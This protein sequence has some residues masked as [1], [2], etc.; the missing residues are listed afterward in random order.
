MIFVAI[1]LFFVGYNLTRLPEIFKSRKDLERRIFLTKKEPLITSAQIFSK[2]KINQSAAGIFNNANDKKKENFKKDIILKEFENYRLLGIIK[3][4][5]AVAFIE[6]IDK[7]RCD[8]FR[9]E[10]FIG[11]FKVIKILSNRVVLGAQ[12]KKKIL[13][14]SITLAKEISPLAIKKLSE[15]EMIVSKKSIL[16]RIIDIVKETNNL[17]INPIS[18]KKEGYIEG[19]MVSNIPTNSFISEFGLKD[20]DIITS[21]NGE[22]LESLPRAIEIFKK[23]KLSKKIEIGIIRNNLPI[24]QTYYLK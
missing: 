13:K 4:I 14:F 16:P 19:L 24:F 7:E 3:G 12:G 1:N 20:S 11:S 15:T 9:E 6:Q 8:M 23:Y 5:Y 17:K 10:D 18:N 21:L 2:T 22:H